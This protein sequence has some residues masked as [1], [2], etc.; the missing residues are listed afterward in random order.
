MQRQPDGRIKAVAVPPNIVTQPIEQREN[1]QRP[2]HGRFVGAQPAASRNQ[3]RDQQSANANRKDVEAAIR[4]KRVQRIFG[5]NIH[6]R[7]DRKT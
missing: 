5:K 4:N 7:S 2:S 1:T 6:R 3:R